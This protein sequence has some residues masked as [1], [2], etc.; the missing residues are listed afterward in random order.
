MDINK[1]IVKS[2]LEKNYSDMKDLVYKSLYAKASLLMDEERVAVAD[3]L[4]NEGS[5]GMYDDDTSAA[6]PA[7]KSA[8][9]KKSEA[10]KGSKPAPKMNRFDE[11]KKKDI[12]SG[13]HT[14]PANKKKYD[15]SYSEY[16]KQQNNMTD[17]KGK[18]LDPYD[19]YQS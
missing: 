8:K 18:K 15:A 10:K 12:N 9:G 4:F 3:V 17:S 7:K 19:D 11:A 5:G 16:I 14:T 1:K 13:V 6:A 2:L